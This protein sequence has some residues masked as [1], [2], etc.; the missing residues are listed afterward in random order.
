MVGP[1]AI[2]EWF[3]ATMNAIR[4]PDA[5]LAAREDYRQL[6]SLYPLVAD[7][8]GNLATL[9]LRHSL[10]RFDSQPVIG[11]AVKHELD[12]LRTTL[13]GETA[14]AIERLLIVRPTAGS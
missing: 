1:Q 13:A 2:D 4:Q 11:E 9:F 7:R 10:S 6:L 5:S 3:T 12:T 14:T 8:Y